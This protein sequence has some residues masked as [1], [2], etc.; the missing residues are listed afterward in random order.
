[1]VL[2]P[3]TS[4]QTKRLPGWEESEVRM[5][6]FL[7]ATFWFSG[8]D[9][10]VLPT[11]KICVLLKS[12]RAKNKCTK[13]LSYCRGGGK[14]LKGTFCTGYLHLCTLLCGYRLCDIRCKNCFYFKK[15]QSISLKE[16]SKNVY[17]TPI[18]PTK[19]PT[20]TEVGKKTQIKQT[21]VFFSASILPKNCLHNYR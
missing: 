6:L 14:L 8:T 1:M 21:K 10:S 20:C 15:A 9:F 13:Y 16:I 5:L 4:R 18:Y 17:C 3:P 7:G 11:H 19:K 12:L 2:E